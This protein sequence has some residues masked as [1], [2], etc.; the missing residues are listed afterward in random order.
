MRSNTINNHS[1]VRPAA[2]VSFV[3]HTLWLSEERREQNALSRKTFFSLFPFRIQAAPDR[4]VVY[5]SAVKITPRLVSETQRC[6]TG[7]EQAAFDL[8]HSCLYSLIN[9]YFYPTEYLLHHG[10]SALFSYNN[11]EAHPHICVLY[12]L[13]WVCAQDHFLMHT[14]RL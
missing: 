8:L 14:I 2:S 12:V 9:I 4:V 5:Y 11:T 1:D 13:L 6:R 7:T 10:R 3:P